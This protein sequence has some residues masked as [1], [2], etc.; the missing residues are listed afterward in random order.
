MKKL[1]I[2]APAKI[3]IG[4]NI[5]SKRN[6]GFHNIETVF[7]PINLFDVLIFTQSDHFSFTCSNPEVTSSGNN[8]V[9]KAIELLEKYSG[10]KINVEVNLKKNIPIGAGM[11]GGSSDAA[12]TLLAMNEFFSLGLNEQK[13]MELALEIGSDVPFFIKP[14]ASFAESRGEKLTLIKL[15][16]TFP[17]L[18]VNPGIHVSTK[19]AYEN[20]KPERNEISLKEILDKDEIDF[21]SINNSVVN[22]FEDVVFQKHPEIKEVKDLLY[23][24]GALF[25]LMTGSGS[26]VFGIFKDMKIIRKVIKKL[27]SNY[28]TF[29]QEVSK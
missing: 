20:I 15:N 19:W 12:G 7:Y 9:L 23:K 21:T 8:S 17:I 16:I 22:D 24:S 4:L 14:F 5:L 3:N 25:S 11:G 27:P 29:I 6:D 2:N 18:I 13:L 26:T 10:K 28:F 1:E